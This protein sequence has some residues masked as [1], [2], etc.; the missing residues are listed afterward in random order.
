LQ[1]EKC[2]LGQFVCSVLG[3]RSCKCEL[4]VHGGASN[5]AQTNSKQTGGGRHLTCIQQSVCLIGYMR[6]LWIRFFKDKIVK[7]TKFLIKNLAR[8]VLYCQF[9]H[10][11]ASFEQFFSRFYLSSIVFF[12]N[13]DYVVCFCGELKGQTPHPPPPTSL[14]PARHERNFGWQGVRGVL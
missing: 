9:L 2:I 10:I 11:S 5:F 4:L 14:P 8:N 3:I 13:R 12:V 1:P 7:S 6:P